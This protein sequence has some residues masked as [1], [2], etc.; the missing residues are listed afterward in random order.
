MS[1]GDGV[2]DPLEFEL[3]GVAAGDASLLTITVDL[4]DLVP[5][6]LFCCSSLRL[7]VTC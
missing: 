5:S 2:T 3:G 6:V 1:D 7:G 4:S